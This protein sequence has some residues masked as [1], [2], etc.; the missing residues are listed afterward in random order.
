LLAVI[1]NRRNAIQMQLH[2]VRR[3]LLQHVFHLLIQ[4]GRINPQRQLP[5]V[6]RLLP[7]ESHLQLFPPPT[8]PDSP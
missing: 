7:R 3:L 1:I 6:Q 2:A 4:V 8:H 5:P